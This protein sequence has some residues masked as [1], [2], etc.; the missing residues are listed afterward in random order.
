MV[1]TLIVSSLIGLIHMAFIGSPVPRS[2]KEENALGKV[3]QFYA[4]ECAFGQHL[5]EDYQ[6]KDVLKFIKKFEK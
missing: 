2:L 1:K 6:C 5:R 3:K 4:Q